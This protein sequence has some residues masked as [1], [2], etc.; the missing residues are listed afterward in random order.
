MARLP[1]GHGA[2]ARQ[3]RDRPVPLPGPLAL[4]RDALV[5]APDATGVA[6]RSCCAVAG[7]PTARDRRNVSSH[8]R[9]PSVSSA[10]VH[11]VRAS[12]CGHSSSH[13]SAMRPAL[14]RRSCATIASCHAVRR[15]HNDAASAVPTLRPSIAYG[16][17][18]THPVLVAHT[19]RAHPTKETRPA[20]LARGDR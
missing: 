1:L 17:I 8:A 12:T 15:R 10:A 6:L 2:S 7:P 18:A 11:S 3:G 4:V 19:C 14:S 5:P 16:L 13:T 20:F 9:G